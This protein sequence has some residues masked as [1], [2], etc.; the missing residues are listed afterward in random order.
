MR[1]RIGIPKK[2]EERMINGLRYWNFKLVSRVMT[3][4]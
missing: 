1:H 2:A 4:L 3:V